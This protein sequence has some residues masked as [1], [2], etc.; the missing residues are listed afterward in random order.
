MTT[1]RITP[2]FAVSGQLRPDDIADVARAGFRAIVNNRPDGEAPDQPHSRELEAQAR[3]CGLAYRHIPF[4]PG[5]MGESDVR[6]LD[7]LK[8]AVDGPILGF[9]RTGARAAQ[10]WALSEAGQLGT[11][12]VVDLAG[13]AGID[14]EAL[15]PRLAEAAAAG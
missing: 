15:R 3:K 8:A 9:C 12:R 11:D 2:Q 10:L 6:A 1:T 4:A 13:K 5:Q 7:A 14:L